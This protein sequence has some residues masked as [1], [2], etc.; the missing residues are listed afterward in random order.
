MADDFVHLHVHT[1]YS[2]LDGMGRVSQLTK[3][4]AELGQP[5][6]AL[7][8]HGTMHGAI[9]FTRACKAAGIKPLLGVEAYITQHGRPMEGRD[10][11]LDKNRHHLLLL[12]Q[13]MTGYRNLLQICSDAQ[14][15]GYYYRPRIDADYLAAHSAGLI[16][17][18][19]CLTAEL[20][21]LLRPRTG[22]YGLIDQE[23]A[24]SAV[25]RDNNNDLV[26]DI[27]DKRGIDRDR[28]AMVVVRPDQ[29]VADVLPLDDRE[30]VAAYFAGILR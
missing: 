26:L 8:D 28:G 5:A 24:F 20:P 1:E 3:R 18:S 25:S 30:T 29:Y 4:A 10:S 14:M 22:R 2:L 11:E 15:K 13:D 17:T 27:Y 6:L 16:C 21:S 19:G 9:E 12:A 7:T 23:K